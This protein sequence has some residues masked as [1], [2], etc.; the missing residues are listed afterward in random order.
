M[1]TVQARVRVPAVMA[2]VGS[3]IAVASFVGSGWATALLVE[4]VTVAATVGYYV[5]GGRDS[6]LGAVVGSRPDERQASIE[7]RA[8]AFAAIVMCAVALVGFVIATALGNA[9]WPFAL[10]SAVGGASFLAGSVGYRARG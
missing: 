2:V 4:A 5:L 7:M 10:F 1:R 8:A 3:A 9:T 6:D